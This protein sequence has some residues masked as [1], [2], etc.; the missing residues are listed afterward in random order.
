MSTASSNNTIRLNKAIADSG[1]CSRR[2]ADRW[3][4]AGR[5][6][7][8]RK[9]IKQLGHLVQSEDVV[10]VDGKPLPDLRKQYLAFHKPIGYLTTRSDDKNRKTIYDLLNPVLHSVDPAGRLDK[11]TSGLLILSN[12]GDFIYKISH[13]KFQI[14]KRYRVTVPKVLTQQAVKRLEEGIMLTPENK[15]AKMQFTG[16]YNVDSGAGNIATYEVILITGYNRQIRRMFEAIGQPVLGLKRVAFGPIALGHLKPGA[17]R[18]LKPAEIKSL[19][20]ETTIPKSMIK[21]WLDQKKP[22]Q[23]KS[24][25]K[26]TTPTQKKTNS[27]SG[28]KPKTSPR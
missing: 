5:V 26:K 8:N 10:Y 23:N 15:L 9:I 19:S 27:T 13:P 18:A 3:I 14:N 1:L 7:I 11:E 12:D 28:R 20:A 17:T 4:L 21:P 22:D 25:R 6:S 16:N 2:E 24:D